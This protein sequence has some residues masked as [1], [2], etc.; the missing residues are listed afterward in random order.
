MPLIFLAAALS[1]M[2]VAA[3]APAP[4]PLDAYYPEAARAAGL[5]GDVVLSCVDQ[6]DKT[7]S[8]CVVVE[9]RPQGKGFG[10]ASLQAA[11]VFR[12]DLRTKDGAPVEGARVRIPIHW[13]LDHK[14][15]P[16]GT[17]PGTTLSH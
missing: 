15:P 16:P 11:G 7:L 13:R 5:E 10:Q 3:A 6:A 14:A 12:V 17:A 9:E 4:D 8:D 1:S 2:A